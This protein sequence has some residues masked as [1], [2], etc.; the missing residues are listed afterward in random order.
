MKLAP[1]QWGETFAAQI[2]QA[3]QAATVPELE[4]QVRD[5]VAQ[6]W[7]VTVGDRLACAL[8]LRVDHTAAGSEGVIV[9]AAGGEPGV[10]LTRDVLPA[11]EQLFSGVR[12]IRIHTA[13]PGLMK[14][15]ARQ[16]YQG[17]EV[18]LTKVIQ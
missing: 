12:A 1:A 10:D 7:G 18:V 3:V 8:V 4:R 5:G 16:G 2:A 14:K 15:L 17:A 11:V 9:A 13:R 6:A